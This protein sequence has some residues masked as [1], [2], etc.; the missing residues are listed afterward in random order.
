MKENIKWYEERKKN[1]FIISHYGEQRTDLL[2]VSISG[3]SLYLCLQTLQY[4][5]TADQIY[6]NWPIKLSGV[7][8]LC[9]IISNFISQ[10]KSK[11][12]SQNDELWA[13][14]NIK[15]I[16]LNEKTS[17]KA[18]D[19]NQEI[20]NFDYLADKYSKSTAFF[21]K[22]SIWFMIGGIC[23]LLGFFLFTF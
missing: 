14:R 9:A 1:A 18:I 7:L 6:S 2:I 22:L 16:E 19:L 8:F 10:L 4:L 20:D 13:D 17:K 5:I 11:K 23:F 12:S 3:A 21:N 15:K